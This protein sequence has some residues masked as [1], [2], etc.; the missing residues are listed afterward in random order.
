MTDS[1]AILEASTPVAAR[2]LERASKGDRWWIFER[3][4]CDVFAQNHSWAESEKY[5]TDPRVRL[6]VAHA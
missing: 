5:L 6:R 2:I 4:Q 3:D 1:N